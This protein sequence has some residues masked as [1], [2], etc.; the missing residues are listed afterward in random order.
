VRC[1]PTIATNP[2]DGVYFDQ[3]SNVWLNTTAE[4]SRGGVISP[5]LPST[6][7]TPERRIRQPPKELSDVCSPRQNDVILARVENV[8]CSLVRNRMANC[9]GRV[10][11]VAVGL[12]ANHACVRQASG[13]VQT[14][15]C[16]RTN[17]NADSKRFHA[18]VKGLRASQGA[19]PHSNRT[20]TRLFHQTPI[21]TPTA[22]RVAMTSAPVFSV[23]PT[24]SHW[25]PKKYP[26]LTK[27]TTQIRPPAYA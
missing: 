1:G 3:L 13:F 10:V 24:R 16:S 4:T 8:C 14:R 23:C 12:N 7:L 27:H 26:R 22:M 17:S 11:G 9:F 5:K 20:Q 19:R 21:S 15:H 18:P 25:S 2:A 6:G